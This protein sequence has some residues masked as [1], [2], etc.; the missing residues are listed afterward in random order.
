MVNYTL[1]SVFRFNEN[2]S[3][4]KSKYQT[5]VKPDVPLL[6]LAGLGDP[7]PAGEGA[8]VLLGDVLDEKAV[9]LDHI[10]VTCGH[11]TL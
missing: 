4:I 9:T 6:Q 10:L 7:G 11:Y 8:R 1:F 2:I 3:V 5:H